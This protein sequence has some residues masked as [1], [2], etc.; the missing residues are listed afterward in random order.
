[1]VTILIHAI[2]M[3]NICHCAVKTALIQSKNANNIFSL[4]SISNIASTAYG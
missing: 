1:M 3:F 4:T 2:Y